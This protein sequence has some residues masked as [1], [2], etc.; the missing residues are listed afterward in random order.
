MRLL[1]IG[2][3]VLVAAED[4]AALADGI[5]RAA[6]LTGTRYEHPHS[7]GNTAQA[8]ERLFTELHKT[9]HS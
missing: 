7:W 9:D 4:P 3:I 2:G 5:R 8:Y 1:R 6:L